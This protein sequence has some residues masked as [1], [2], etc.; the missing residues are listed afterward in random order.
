MRDGCTTVEGFLL[1]YQPLG[2]RFGE[3][4]LY[5]LHTGKDLADTDNGNL[6]FGII[7]NLDDLLALGVLID[8]YGRIALDGCDLID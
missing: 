3:E 4:I 5:L 2:V 8:E 1:H 6:T 7:G